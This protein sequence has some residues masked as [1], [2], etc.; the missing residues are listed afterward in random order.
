MQSGC[1]PPGQ[2]NSLCMLPGA[3]MM[4]PLASLV[5]QCVEWS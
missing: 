3:V 2:P 4:G 1:Q 5:I